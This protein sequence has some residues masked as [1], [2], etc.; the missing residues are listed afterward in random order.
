MLSVTDLRQIDTAAADLSRI[1]PRADVDVASTVP[2]V[3]PIL[4]QVRTGG[5]AALLE[6]AERFDGVRPPALRVPAEALAA[7]LDGLDADVRAALEESIRRARLVHA[8]QLPQD[9]TVE[10]GEGASVLLGEPYVFDA[11]NIADFDF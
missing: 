2:V 7:A 3:A 4:E 9:S 8:A 11:E 5:E 1:I 10:L 6:L